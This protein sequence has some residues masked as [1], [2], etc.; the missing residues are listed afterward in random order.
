[1]ARV[2]IKKKGCSRKNS[3]TCGN[4]VCQRTNTELAC[5]KRHYSIRHPTRV[6]ELLVKKEEHLRERISEYNWGTT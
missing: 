3:R 6:K 5:Y 2:T 1:M 4:V